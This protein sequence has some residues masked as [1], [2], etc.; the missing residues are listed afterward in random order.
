ML[1]KADLGI[2]V[3][4]LEGETARKKTSDVEFKAGKVERRRTEG[5]KS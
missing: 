5:C 4:G 1:Q 3:E 2:L